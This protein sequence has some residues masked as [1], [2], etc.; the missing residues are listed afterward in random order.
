MRIKPNREVAAISLRAIR[1][2]SKFIMLTLAVTS[3]LNCLWFVYSQ[4]VLAQ[5]PSMSGRFTIIIDP[6]IG[7]LKMKLFIGIALIIATIA[8]WFRKILGFIVSALAL[9]WLG[10]EYVI[11]WI[12][13][14]KMVT[15]SE[16]LDFSKVPHKLYLYS[17]SWWDIWV[18]GV[19]IV[20]L[21]WEL[22]ILS[23]Y[24]RQWHSSELSTSPKSK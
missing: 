6:N 2:S 20:I 7:F 22:T 14:S 15:N 18:F 12:E 23:K 24:Y 3:T 1:G 19:A 10:F 21:A 9:T 4:M 5:E 11:W 8:L 13:S 16:A 17:A